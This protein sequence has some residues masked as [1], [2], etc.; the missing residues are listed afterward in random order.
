MK[1]LHNLGQWLILFAC[2]LSNSL[3]AQTPG[4][5]YSISVSVTHADCYMNGEIAITLSGPALTGTTA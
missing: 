5:E 3:S 4:C 2:L 1:I